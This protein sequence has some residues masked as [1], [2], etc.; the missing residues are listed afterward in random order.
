[1]IFAATIDYAPDKARIAEIRPVHRDYQ[2]GLR[3]QNKLVI[4]GPF[5]DDSGGLI[6]YNAASQ[7]EVESIIRN[8]PFY[9]HGVFQS[10]VIREWKIVKAN[11]DL[12][13]KE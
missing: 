7:E 2:E 9:K 4:A 10:W 13:P 3:K 5:A 6:V 12:L 8:D 11:F 1:M